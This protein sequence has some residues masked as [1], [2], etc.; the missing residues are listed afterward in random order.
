MKERCEIDLS[1]GTRAAPDSGGDLRAVAGF[2]AA[3][4]DMAFPW[5]KTPVAGH[6]LLIW[7]VSYHGRPKWS[8][9]GSRSLQAG[10]TSL[11]LGF[12]SAVNCG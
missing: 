5:M 9:P 2:G 12:D 3:E 1:P 11:A 8:S 4:C 10:F 7:A 6:F